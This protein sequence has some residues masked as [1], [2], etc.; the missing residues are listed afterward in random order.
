M[1]DQKDYSADCKVSKCCMCPDPVKQNAGN[2]AAQRHANTLEDCPDEPLEID[3]NRAGAL[4]NILRDSFKV[5][6]S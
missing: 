1:Q 2:K 3:K 6:S 5:T 4:M